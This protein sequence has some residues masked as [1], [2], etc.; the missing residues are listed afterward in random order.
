MGGVGWVLSIARHDLDHFAIANLSLLKLSDTHLCRI[1]NPQEDPEGEKW[2]EVC[3]R[4][5]SFV[6]RTRV[7]GCQECAHRLWAEEVR[8]GNRFGVWV[9]FDEEEQSETYAEQKVGKCPKCGAW[10]NTDTLLGAHDWV[11]GR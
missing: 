7:V 6:R 9:C 4:W 5:R 1:S 3:R 11:R 8:V 2:P 10:L